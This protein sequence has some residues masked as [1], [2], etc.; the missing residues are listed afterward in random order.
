MCLSVGDDGVYGADQ[1]VDVL[2]VCNTERLKVTAT[3]RQQ[4]VNVSEFVSNERVGVWRE[5]EWC[6]PVTDRRRSVSVWNC[7][8]HWRRRLHT[9]TWNIAVT[10]STVQYP[11]TLS[12]AATR[13]LFRGR[14]RGIFLSFPPLSFVFFSAPFVF[15]PFLSSFLRLEVAPRIQ[16]RNLE[17]DISSHSEGERH[18]QPP[19]RHVSWALNAP[20]MRLRRRPGHRPIFGVF[21]AQKACLVAVTEI[22]LLTYLFRLLV[23]CSVM[24]MASRSLRNNVTHYNV[25]YYELK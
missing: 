21:R 13:N 18:L 8:C 17:S 22:L 9:D 19:C 6:E 10:D 24:A 2:T 15:F 7:T 20:K 25:I 3:E 12:K 5:T 16:L 4:L 11:G 1:Y 14:W 23:Q